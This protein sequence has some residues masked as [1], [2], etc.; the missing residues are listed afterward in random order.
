MSRRLR[1]S[2]IGQGVGRK[3]QIGTIAAGA[4]DEVEALAI[5]IDVL[6]HPIFPTEVTRAPRVLRPP[7]RV[8]HF[9]RDGKSPS[10]SIP[11]S[12]TR[13]EI[14]PSLRNL[15]NIVVK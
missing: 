3:S 8:L 2:T 5:V 7:V 6:V 10:E 9:H 14:G 13:N 11:G 12:G 1:E 15:R 4:E